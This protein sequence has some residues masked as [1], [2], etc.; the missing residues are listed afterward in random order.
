MTLQALLVSKD[1]NAAEALSRVLAGFAVAVERSSD[2]EV[3]GERVAEQKFD[4][5]IVDFDDPE[6]A[7]RILQSARQ[8]ASGANPV[9]V[10]LISDESKVRTTFGAGANFVLT[11]PVSVE[12]ATATLR[13]ATALL[14]HERRRSFRVSLQTAVQLSLPAGQEIEG[15]MLDL[16]ETGM[17]V[18]SA[19]PLYPSATVGFR[20][21]LPDGGMQISRVPIAEMPAELKQV[22]EEMK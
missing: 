14:K 12:P 3:A 1:D 22:I 20:F 4:A 21:S 19:Q 11:K 10:A 7:T 6:A 13:A 17:D 8:L 18:L 16:S 2:F 5:V 9:S 15:I